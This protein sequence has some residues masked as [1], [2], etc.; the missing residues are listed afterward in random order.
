VFSQYQTPDGTPAS[1]FWTVVRGQLK[2]PNNPSDI[3]RI[4]HATFSVPPSLGYTVSDIKI[5]G[6]PIQYASQI[7]Q[8]VGS[9]GITMAL[10]ATAFAGGGPNQTGVDCTVTNDNPTSAA[11]FLQ[12]ASVFAAYPNLNLYNANNQL[13]NAQQSYLYLP[14]GPSSYGP[15]GAIEVKAAWKILTPTELGT[16]PVRFLT[17]PALVGGG[18]SPVT[19]GLVGL[20]VMQRPAGEYQGFWAT[21]A[22]TDNCPVSGQVGTNAYSFYNADCPDCASNVPTKPPTGT[23]LVQVTDVGA[24]AAPINAW[25]QKT[26]AA[27]NSNSPLQFYQLIDVLWPTAAVAG[28][29]QSTRN[30]SFCHWLFCSNPARQQLIISP[31]LPAAARRLPPTRNP[32]RSLRGPRP[33]VVWR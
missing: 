12:D 10:L 4:L 19:V 24:E 23:Q 11:S 7:A 32:G 18:S 3:D 9:G 20:H 17:A 33:Y 2:D 14:V 31:P 1:Q 22:Q 25:M 29:T 27:S 21:F 5:A 13:T 26:I 16:Q 15:V 28:L 8:Q 30:I 6:Q